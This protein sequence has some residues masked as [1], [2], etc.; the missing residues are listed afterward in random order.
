MIF[1]PCSASLRSKLSQKFP[2]PPNLT[3]AETF[4]DK[5]TQRKNQLDGGAWFI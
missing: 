2:Y 3:E 1:S 5:C 4:E